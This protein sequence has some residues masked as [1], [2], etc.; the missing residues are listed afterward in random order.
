MFGERRDHVDT[1]P[2]AGD[3]FRRECIAETMMQGGFKSTLE[4]AEK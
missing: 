3:A 1:P 2:L 4:Y